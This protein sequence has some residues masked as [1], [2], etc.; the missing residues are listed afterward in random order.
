VGEPGQVLADHEWEGMLREG[1]APARPSWAQPT[2][3]ALPKP[4]RKKD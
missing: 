1:K 4:G 3:R 2:A